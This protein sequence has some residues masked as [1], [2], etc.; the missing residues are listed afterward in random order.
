MKRF[1]LAAVLAAV[2]LSPAA[3]R[4]QS[5]LSGATPT[6][7]PVVWQQTVNFS[8]FHDWG[9]S[10]RSTSGSVNG[11]VADDFDVV[12]SISRIDVNGFG[13]ETGAPE[14][15][16]IYVRFYAFGADSLPGAQQAEYFIPK[17]DPRILNPVSTSDFRVDLGTP[18]QAS[19]KH[20]VV[21]QVS[22]DGGWYWRSADED[23]PR[24]TAVYFRDPANGQ[25]TWSHAFPFS[26]TANTD[27]AFTLYGTRT[28][29]A[30][31]I[32][33]LSVATLPQAGRLKISGSGFGA[34]QGS[35]TVKIGA[36]TAPVSD[37]T[38]SLITAY[39]PDASA[40]GADNVQVITS[41]G[42]S[43]PKVLTVTARQAAGHVL[44]RLQTSGDYIIGR[45]AVG[46]DG[47]IYTA[48]V[49]NHLYA[50]TP[51]GG[52]K[53]IF[54]PGLGNVVQ[55]V[56]VGLDGTI[57][58][59]NLD[60]VYAVNP[61]GSLKWV[62]SSGGQYIFAGPTAGPDGNI[63]AASNNLN[64]PGAVGSFVLSP[65]GNLISHLEDFSTRYVYSGIE[66][67]FGPTNQWYFTNNASGAVSSAG[68]LF[69]FELGSTTLKWFQGAERQPRLQP[70][71]NTVVGDGNPV[72]PGLESFNSSGSLLWRSLGE[73]PGSL[74]PGIDAQTQID[75]GSDGNIYV[76]TLKYGT[77][78][79]MTSLNAGGTL[80]WQFP[81]TGILSA[82]AVSPTN[83]SLLYSAADYNT[84]S[85]VV[86]L[87][88]SGALLWRENL[89]VENGANIQV[90]SVPRFSLDGSA[91]YVGTS[92][93][94]ITGDAY[95]YL[96]A[97]DV[98]G[99][100][101]TFDVVKVTAAQYVAS[102]KQLTVKAT[103]SDSTA[104]LSVYITSTNTLL[105][106]LANKRGTYS[107]KFTVTANPVN[108][109]VKSSKGGSASKAVTSK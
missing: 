9:P 53:W 48:D 93:S 37:W 106:N 100:S 16:G 98:A 14:F 51:Q 89:P 72:H 96:Y 92:V 67:L 26:G 62:F 97:F 40:L 52:V 99:G 58:Y 76:G 15:L 21:M 90:L 17:G 81:E 75:A 29:T 107:G 10:Q 59:A 25:P 24:G 56:S 63:Y 36:A 31:T 39:V 103:S 69:A 54:N 47:T 73:L 6:P 43:N 33:S 88:T 79:F 45:P 35:G 84:P 27:V 66:V 44:W 4:A 87:T 41:G 83:G 85:H 49:T 8:D 105:G 55:P 104:V 77:G 32:T 12:G 7:P 28:L 101:Q 60:D 102:R 13:V 68:A 30:P 61:D 1:L 22:G 74:V 19:G 11:E 95:G 34:T 2:T 50:L 80:R 20:F 64:F 42:V 23:A 46:A 5:D 94:S 38:D 109:T 82:P 108:I 57:Y 78:V 65:A 70:S 18:F 86:A 71:G 91:A 3:G